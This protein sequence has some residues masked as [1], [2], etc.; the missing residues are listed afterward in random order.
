M[1]LFTL[2]SPVPAAASATASTLNPS[3]DLTMDL[4]S[5]IAAGD[6]LVFEVSHHG[7]D[8]LTPPAGWTLGAREISTSRTE[9]YWRRATGSEG[10][11]I[12]VQCPEAPIAIGQ[13]YGY[14]G[15]LAAGDPV[16][17]VATRANLSGVTGG[18]ALN[19]LPQN[20]LV[21]V[22]VGFALQA[23]MSPTSSCQFAGIDPPNLVSVAN[24]SGNGTSDLYG[25]A[26]CGLATRYGETVVGGNTG[27]L[28]WT[29]SPA[30][31]TS[32]IVIAFAAEPLPV[33]APPNA[34]PGSAT[35]FTSLP[36]DVTQEAHDAGVTYT[37]WFKYTAV[38][39]DNI[40]SVWG[41]GP[42]YVTYT[43]QTRVYR[44]IQNVIE[45]NAFIDTG[46]GNVLPVMVQVT[47]GETYY[48]EFVRNAGNPT[49]ATLTV[50]IERFI[51]STA[52]I[53]SLVIPGDSD[54]DTGFPAGIVSAVADQ[55]FHQFRQDLPHSEAG[56]VLS[57]GRALIYDEDAFTVQRL[58]PQLAPLGSALANVPVAGSFARLIRTCAGT[59]RWWVAGRTSGT[60]HACYVD[61]DGTV[62][63]DHAVAV[64]FNPAGI[65]VAN[66]E[67]ILY[68]SRS[69]GTGP[70]R[71]IDLATDMALSDLVPADLM[72]RVGDLIMLPDDTLLALYWGAGLTRTMEVRRFDA[73]GTLLDTYSFGTDWNLPFGFP[74][75]LA[76]GVDG[77]TFW[78]WGWPSNTGGNAHAIH[79]DVATGTVLATRTFANYQ[80][81]VYQGGEEDPPDSLYGVSNT[82]PFWVARVAITGPDATIIVQKVV[83]PPDAT[84]FAFTAGG[85]LSPTSFAL[86]HGES[87][88]FP[89]VPVGSGYTVA[90]TPD[91]AYATQVAVS[92][93]SPIDNLRVDPGETVIVTF[94]NTRTPTGPTACP[95]EDWPVSAP[96]EGACAV[97]NTFGTL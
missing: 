37:L 3:G 51:E 55:T 5:V 36:D 16:L 67:S 34:H 80:F 8:W 90:E 53:G 7:S 47:A 22:S 27:A 61:P 12:T 82:C 49:P 95:T 9:L 26:T 87:Q 19:S 39:G 81:G 72:L 69:G 96:S 48:F 10:A 45:G 32:V 35:E 91:P 86:V 21:I 42:D 44:G 84:S 1:N 38:A 85:G 79:V 64:S 30:A 59:D 54:G 78:L 94:T 14:T 6:L 65:A 4:P 56:D 88:T 41:R 29:Q 75:R 68:W 58:D 83:V 71:R 33:T 28:A 77:D 52:P 97:P 18:P 89:N 57:T 15:L 46:A 31:A 74:P 2:R 43:P 92:N 50:E 13:T 24:L 73:A 11:T 93:G 66:D 62:G 70:I 76:V 63:P 17:A 60:M 23:F 40:L 25:S 20:A